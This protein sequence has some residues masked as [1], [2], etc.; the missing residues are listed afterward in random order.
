MSNRPFS[1]RSVERSST[2]AGNVVVRAHTH[3]Q[4]PLFALCLISV[5][6]VCWNSG[7][8]RAR[9]RKNADSDAYEIIDQHANM[10]HWN[11]PRRSIEIDPRSRMF[12]PFDPDEPP[13]PP[14]DP[15]ANLMLQEV[16]GYRGFAG[17]DDAEESPHVENPVW[18]ERLPRDDRGVVVLDFDTALELA[19]VHSSDLQEAYEDLYLSALD[20][21]AER[22]DFDSQLFAGSDG[23]Y[24]AS[25]R[26]S[27][28]PRSRLSIDSEA[29]AR[30]SY[31]TGATLVSS[32]A[33]ALVWDFHGD[34]SQSVFSVLDFSLVQPLLRGAGRD[35]ILAQLTLAERQ[36]LY[37]IRQMER[38]R[39]AFYLDIAT[40]SNGRTRAPRRIGGLFGGSGLQGFTGVGGGFGGVGGV[41]T[42]GGFAQQGGDQLQVG[43]FIGLLQARQGIRNN[44]ANIM[45]LRTSLLQ[46]QDTL[47]ENLR[48]IPDDP[49]EIVRNR[50]QIAQARQTL[51][52]AEFALITA[53]S[54]YQ[55]FLDTFKADLGL[56]PKLPVRIEDPMLDAFNLLDTQI[57]PLQE[58]A[59]N[60]NLNIGRINEQ[61]LAQI[62]FIEV[63]G[64]QVP[65]IEWNDSVAAQLSQLNDYVVR[66]Q[67]MRDQLADE[68]I[69]RA[70]E[71]I[72]R[73][74]T[75]LPARRESLATLSARYSGILT[76]EQ[77]LA[78]ESQTRLPVDIDPAILDVTRL[79]TLVSQLGNEQQRLT[80]QFAIYTEPLKV[81]REQLDRL[82]SDDPKPTPTELYARLESQLLFKVPSLVSDLNSD[83]LDLSL[84]Q[85]RARA[86]SI[87]LISVNM[88]SDE[89]LQIASI[90]RRDW[91]NARASLMDTWRA[92]A[93]VTNDLEGVLDLVAEGDLD[94]VG[95]N[96]LKFRSTTSSFRFGVQFDAPLTRLL[97]RNQ[98]RQVLIDYQQAKRQYYQFIDGVSQTLRGAL[99]TIMLNEL[100]F[101]SRRISVLSAI[102]QI[103]LNDEIQTLVEERGTLQ[104]V[105]AARD[106]AD[107]LFALQQAQ[108][109]LLGVWATYEVNRRFLD[110]HLGT[111][112]LDENSKWIDPGSIQAGQFNQSELPGSESTER[113]L[114]PDDELHLEA[115]N[116]VDRPATPAN[117]R[118]ASQSRQASDRAGEGPQRLPAT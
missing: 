29:V 79:D 9:Y 13:K 111:M 2:H 91:M 53:E 14:D 65:A 26:S 84:L 73:L 6:A 64:A 76:P 107:A 3:F 117:A 97:E 105:T 88:P 89:A 18:L 74:K 56:P 23:F 102:D 28:Q 103:V 33:N 4:A 106:I 82:L 94:T 100:N 50:L 83:I 1:A 115:A 17:W 51:Y 99:R 98:Y 86:D 21:S 108:D 34:N 43:G 62:R 113:M 92:I 78:I 35:R 66:I 59:T 31:V 38:F 70:G 5:V 55:S 48:K 112:Q 110:F 114:A 77:T 101:E 116:R 95:D 11:L 80:N 27:G 12:D 8:S 37:N 67:A 81:F 10:P 90:N 30:K 7:C 19:M 49:T 20:V 41:F 63:D 39:R 40:G 22:F 25:G 93:F 24:Q 61:L 87:E 118:P 36:L 104:G 42:G 71:D 47:R 32:F 96:P 58:Q 46:F 54:G 68:N 85:A 75:I 57:T 45:G 52:T 69:A 44:Q 15:S 16:N 109:D 72:E 60:L